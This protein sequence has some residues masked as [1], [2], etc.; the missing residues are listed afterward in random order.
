MYEERQLRLWL[1]SIPFWVLNFFGAHM[2]FSKYELL[3]DVRES[4]VVESGY[5]YDI[6]A[7]TVDELV[8]FVDAKKN[9]SKGNLINLSKYRNF[10]KDIKINVKNNR[11]KVVICDNQTDNQENHFTDYLCASGGDKTY[12][13]SVYV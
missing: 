7:K 12:R 9:N 11:K 4:L 6:D 2:I 13:S 10:N 1:M 8:T 3:R 5:S